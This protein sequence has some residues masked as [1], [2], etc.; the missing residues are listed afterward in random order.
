MYKYFAYGLNISSEIELNELIPKDFSE[1]V[2]VEITLAEVP[3]QITGPNWHG[4]WWQ[5]DDEY[6]LCDY[7]DIMR[8]LVSRNGKDVQVQVFTQDD[9]QLRSFIY[10]QIFSAVLLLRG[11]YLLHGACIKIGDKA[12]GL[13]GP[14]G[15]G[16]STLALGFMQEGFTVY[17]DDVIALKVENYKLMLYPGFPRLRI[18]SDVIDRMSLDSNSFKAIEHYPGKMKYVSKFNFSSQVIELNELLILNPTRCEKPM[19]RKLGGWEKLNLFEKANYRP[20]I[21]SFIFS[22]EE[23]LEQRSEIANIT[24]CYYLDRPESGFSLKGTLSKIVSI[25]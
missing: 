21:E 13:C 14:S 15:V 24:K 5:A 22:E 8:A 19:L 25:V 20:E 7:T 1:E 18:T 11:Y 16:K 3:E 12:V 6:L 17:S 10:S 9:F 4:S 23:M 2:D